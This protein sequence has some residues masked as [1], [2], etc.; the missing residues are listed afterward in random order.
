[1]SRGA[2]KYIEENLEDK[3]TLNSIA[4]RERVSPFYLHRIFKKVTGLTPKEYLES[5]RLRR[6]SLSL[7][8]GESI[9]K[10]TYAAGYNTSSWLYSKPNTKLGMSPSE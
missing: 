10:S 4:E 7:R 8:K 9:T 1:M 6:L 5:F 2:C 3:I